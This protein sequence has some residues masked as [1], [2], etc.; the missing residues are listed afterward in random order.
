VGLQLFKDTVLV[1]QIAVT[2]N[3]GTYPW[4]AAKTSLGSGDDY[5]IRI[6]SAMDPSIQAVRTSG[7]PGWALSEI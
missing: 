2:T 1:N 7:R 4:P 5:R 6:F 3:V